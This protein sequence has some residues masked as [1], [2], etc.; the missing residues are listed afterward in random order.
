VTGGLGAYGA[1]FG[2][3]DACLPTTTTARSA[4]GGAARFTVARQ[5]G[6][7]RRAVGAGVYPDV[8]HEEGAEEGRPEDRYDDLVDELVGI[9]G[10][11]PPRV[12]VVSAGLPCASGTRSL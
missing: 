4:A 3:Q 1:G 8:V 6:Q 11:T 5:L 9:A 2:G 10:V 12:T 7:A